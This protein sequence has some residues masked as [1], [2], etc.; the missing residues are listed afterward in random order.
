MMD[1]EVFD[2]MANDLDAKIN[3]VSD[4]IN[5]VHSEGING[6]EAMIM[7]NHLLREFSPKHRSNFRQQIGSL[8]K[9]GNITVEQKKRMEELLEKASRIVDDHSARLSKKLPKGQGMYSS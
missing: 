9:S 8:Y 6:V 1:P 7:Q 2:R 5:H 3:T 4:F